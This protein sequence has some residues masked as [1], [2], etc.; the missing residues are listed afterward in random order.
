MPGYAGAGSEAGF[1]FNDDADAT[2]DVR[3]VAAVRV[4]AAIT[5]TIAA[6]SSSSP[7]PS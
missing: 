6:L 4:I 1:K 5:V 2:A 7:A 3:P